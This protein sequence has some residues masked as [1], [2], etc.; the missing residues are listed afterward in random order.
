MKTAWWSANRSN[1]ALM[2]DELHELRSPIKYHLV[3]YR[4]EPTGVRAGGEA[5]T[6]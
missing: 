6:P 5:V 1:Q 4:I 2:P 3:L